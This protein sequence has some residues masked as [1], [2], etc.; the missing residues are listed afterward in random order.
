MWICLQRRRPWFYSWVG[1]IP[2]KRDRLPTPVFLG[3]PG[4]SADRRIHLQCG[5]PGF[6]LWVGEIPWI[7]E[8]L[9]SP[10]FWPGEFHGPH[11]PW[12]SKESDM[13][14]WL[15]L[16]LLGFPGGSAGK[17]TSCNERPVFDHWIGKIPW[18]REW[19]PTPVFWFRAFHGLYSPWGH[20]ESD[21]TEWLA[22]S[23]GR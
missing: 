6:A 13:T 21:M 18:R 23:L 3:F 15:S 8:Q 5:R 17:E 11:S 20:K 9:P 22:L 16:S 4:G 2:W 1:T 12:G 14:E 19:L 7:G 10:V